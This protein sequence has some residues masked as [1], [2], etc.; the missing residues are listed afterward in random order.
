MTHGRQSPPVNGAY[1]LTR[2]VGSLIAGLI[3][4]LLLVPAGLL[5]CLG[6]ILP[7]PILAAVPA[8]R[9]LPCALIGGAGLVLDG[10]ALRAFLNLGRGTQMPFTPT[11]NLVTQGPFR[12]IRNPILLGV[13]AFYFAVVAAPFGWFAGMAV[14]SVSIVC[15]GLFYRLVEEP[16]LEHRFGDAYREYRSSTPFLLPGHDR[17]SR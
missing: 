9:W 16:Q 3:V 8:S 14:L 1:S 4:F 2:T 10:L 13:S 11:T 17:R 15:G 7:L 6:W 12:V 5:L